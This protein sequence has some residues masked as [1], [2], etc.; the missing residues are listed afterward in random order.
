MNVVDLT[1]R[2]VAATVRVD[3]TVL[4]R[5][6]VKEI[7]AGVGVLVELFSKTDQYSAWV[8]LDNVVGLVVPDVPDEPAD[9]TWLFAPDDLALS[10]GI[11]VFHRDDGSAPNEPD[12]RW[13]RRWQL[14]GTAE[15]LDWPTACHRGAGTA[16]PIRQPGP[17]NLRSDAGNLPRYV[18][19]WICAILQR[20]TAGIT[21]YQMIRWYHLNQRLGETREGKTI[22]ASDP[23]VQRR[24]QAYLD[25]LVA[26]G[27]AI[28]HSKPRPERQPY[29]TWSTT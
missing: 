21:M 8:R 29:W 17:V 20:R 6:T 1:E 4:I 28:F 26:L 23:E 12:R 19:E 9:G 27:V 13:P 5:G 16:Q 2:T 10:D 11:N 14:A 15:W 22:P 18:Q 7:V 3:D 25:H 24:V